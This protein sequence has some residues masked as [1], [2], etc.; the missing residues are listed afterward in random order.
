[1]TLPSLPLSAQVEI[2]REKIAAG[3]LT[4]EE[5]RQAIEALRAGRVTAAPTR[6]KSAA[7]D[8]EKLLSDLEGL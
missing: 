3:T 5:A 6:G 8:S 2:W 4:I 1:M 7:V